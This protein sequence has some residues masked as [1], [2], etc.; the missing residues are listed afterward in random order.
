MILQIHY[1]HLP[2][3]VRA[4]EELAISFEAMSDDFA[5]AMITDRR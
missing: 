5:T 1:P 2:R 3:T 4:A